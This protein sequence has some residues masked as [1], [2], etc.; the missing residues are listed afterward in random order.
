VACGYKK[1]EKTGVSIVQP[2][3]ANEYPTHIG[4]LRRRHLWR[5]MSVKSARTLTST[6][7]HTA[8]NR[9]NRCYTPRRH[10]LFVRFQFLLDFFRIQFLRYVDL[11]FL[12]SVGLSRSRPPI[13]LLLRVLGHDPLVVSRYFR[14]GNTLGAEDLQVNRF[15]TGQRILDL[16]QRLLV[17]LFH[18]NAQTC[19]L[20]A[21]ARKT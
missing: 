12:R 7:T 21:R 8:T 2:R 13:G 19:S 11:G 5:S 18:V 15:A 3:R 17:D 16:L 4:N 1:K 20:S 6:R 10:C 14:L 9:S